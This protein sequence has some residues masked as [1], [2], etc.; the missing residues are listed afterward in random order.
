[1]T[2][3]ADFGPDD[4]RMQVEKTGIDGS[5][6]NRCQA[7]FQDALQSEQGNEPCHQEPGQ[8]EPGG[9]VVDRSISGGIELRREAAT[10]NRADR[11]R[12]DQGTGKAPASQ[13][14]PI[15]HHRQPPGNSDKRAEKQE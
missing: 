12:Q 14:L 3:T 10:R 11:R 4:I 5:L 9:E 7:P 6:F 8:A 1:M 13:R 2:I 15:I